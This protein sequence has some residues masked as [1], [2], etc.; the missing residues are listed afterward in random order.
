MMKLKRHADNIIVI[1][2]SEAGNRVVSGSLDGRNQF[3]S[4]GQQI[5]QFHIEGRRI[6]YFH[7]VHK[8]VSKTYIYFFLLRPGARSLPANGNFAPVISDSRIKKAYVK[9]LGNST[10]TILVCEESAPVQRLCH[11]SD[12]TGVWVSPYLEKKSHIPVQP[13]RDLNSNILFRQQRGTQIFNFVNYF[14]TPES[15]SMAPARRRPW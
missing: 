14:D 9:E 10:N 3:W 15:V 8:N 13:W 12:Q 4:I 5:F 7:Q 11:N 1:V 6:V 2:I